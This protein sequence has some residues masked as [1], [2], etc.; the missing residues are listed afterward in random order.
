M[1]FLKNV[2]TFQGRTQRWQHQQAELFIIVLHIFILCTWCPHKHLGTIHPLPH[3]CGKSDALPLVCIIFK[4]H[5]C[6]A[7]GVQEPHS[8]QTSLTEYYLGVRTRVSRFQLGNT[9]FTQ[10]STYLLPIPTST[11]RPHPSP[12]SQCSAFDRFFL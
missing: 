1:I 12:L 11:P 6:G 8:H 9:L 5:A 4:L 7:G 2:L 10:V 3:A